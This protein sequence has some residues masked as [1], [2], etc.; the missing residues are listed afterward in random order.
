MP[1]DN[2]TSFDYTDRLGIQKMPP[3]YLLIGLDSGHFMWER[4][5][6]EEESAIHWNKWEVWRWAWQD[7]NDRAAGVQ[8]E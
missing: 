7:H 4:T 6:D 3:G 2:V 8:D 1:A 5:S